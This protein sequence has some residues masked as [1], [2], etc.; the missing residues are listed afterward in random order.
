MT[1][2]KFKNKKITVEGVDYV[3]QKLPLLEGLKVKKTWLDKNLPEGIDD[4]KMYEAVLEYFVISPKREI[5]DFDDLEELAKLS[6]E[7]LEF[8]FMGKSK[9][10]GLKAK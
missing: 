6:A 3:I 4:I 2:S 1:E 5:N 9:E 10:I 7:C 8:Q